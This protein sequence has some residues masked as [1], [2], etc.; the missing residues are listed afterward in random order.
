[1]LGVDSP[2]AGH[3][4]LHDLMVTR[5]FHQ[6]LPASVRRHLVCRVVERLVP[7]TQKHDIEGLVLG[8]DE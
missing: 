5:A 8:V 6:T 1:V 3:A 7:V 2:G 4:A